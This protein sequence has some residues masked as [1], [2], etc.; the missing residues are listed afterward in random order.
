MSY[1][2]SECK[3]SISAE[4]FYYSMNRYKKA[5]CG[6]HQRCSSISGTT[7]ELQELVRSRH[8]DEGTA[9]MPQLK[10]VKDWINADFDTW[11]K[12]LKKKDE[13]R[14]NTDRGDEE[15]SNDS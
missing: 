1:Y 12:V 8:A 14:L 5:L 2:C 9:E 10:T 7:R 13:E 4:E 11:D 6:D 3:K 15:K